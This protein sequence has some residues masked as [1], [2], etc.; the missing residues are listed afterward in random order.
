MWTLPPERTPVCVYVPHLNG[1]LPHDLAQLADI[2]VLLDGCPQ[3][4][5]ILRL[6]LGV[7]AKRSLQ[8]VMQTHTH[9]S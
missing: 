4:A 5:V 1:P 2:V 8:G 7:A 6:G 3:V 9:F